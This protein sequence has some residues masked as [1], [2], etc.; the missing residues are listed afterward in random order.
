MNFWVPGKV[1]KSFTGWFMLASVEWLLRE[2]SIE[3][4]IVNGKL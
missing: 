2:F 4:I 3:N 1:E